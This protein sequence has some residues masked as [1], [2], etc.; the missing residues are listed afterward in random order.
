MTK[1]LTGLL[2][3]SA[4]ITGVGI[5]RAFFN[6]QTNNHAPPATAHV[7]SGLETITRQ[8]I[9]EYLKITDPELKLQK[10]NEVL[11]KI[12][13]IFLADLGLKI[14]QADLKTLE[15]PSSLPSFDRPTNCQT[16]KTLCRQKLRTQAERLKQEFSPKKPPRQWSLAEKKITELYS[17]E[18]YKKFLTEAAI[19]NFFSEIKSAQTLNNK[20]TEELNGVFVGSVEFFDPNTATANARIELAAE[21]EAQK[22]IGKSKVILSRDGKPFSSNNGN[23]QLSSYSQPGG[24]NSQAI[25]V[26]AGGS[27]GYFQLYFVQNGSTL[28][29]NYYKNHGVGNYRHAGTIQLQRL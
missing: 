10:A 18:D 13:T 7:P 22:L 28:I 14:S 11:A 23:G 5:G 1:T 17:E 2:V 15:S 20:K 6:N 29:G 16:E 4:L 21:L 12:M 3:G 19:N 24:E 8:D 25:F 26:N 9:P 27:F